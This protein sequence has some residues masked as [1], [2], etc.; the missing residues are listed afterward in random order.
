MKH[1]YNYLAIRRAELSTN[2]SPSRRPGPGSPS[3]ILSPSDDPYPGGPLGGATLPLT[4]KR[5]PGGKA[6]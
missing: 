3:P 1:K 2:S 4:P 6:G 5:P